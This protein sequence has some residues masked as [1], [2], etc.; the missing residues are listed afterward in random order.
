MMLHNPLLTLSQCGCLWLAAR[1][2]GS[3]ATKFRQPRVLGELLAGILLG[4]S[5]VGYFFPSYL[6]TLFPPNGLDGLRTIS[7]IGLILFMFYTGFEINIQ[8]LRGMRKSA[9]FSSLLGVAIPLTVGFALGADMGKI[10]EVSGIR[11]E[12]QMEARQLV[13]A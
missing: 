6:Q 12:G 13:T 8:R 2:G 9:F 4:P 1:I 10:V 7:E 3:V 11:N 5:L